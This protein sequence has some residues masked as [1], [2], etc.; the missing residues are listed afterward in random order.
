MNTKSLQNPKEGTMPDKSLDKH[1]SVPVKDIYSP[2]PRPLPGTQEDREA[3]A[4][5]DTEELLRG[6]R[7]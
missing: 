7:R 2:A 3:R 1:G 5:A 4:I 6:G